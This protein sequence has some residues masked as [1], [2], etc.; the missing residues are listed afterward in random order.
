M[1]AAGEWWWVIPLVSFIGG[2]VAAWGLQSLVANWIT[3]PVI[4]VRLDNSKGSTGEVT[5]NLFDRDGKL[6][7]QHQAKY[8]RLHVE[9]T[10]LSTIKNCSGYITKLTRTVGGQRTGDESEVLDL[11][12]AHK[13]SSNN[14]RDIPSG[15]FFHMDVATLHLLS[16]PDGKTLRPP[17]F[18]TTTSLKDFFKPRGTYELEV[19]I[20]ADNARLPGT[21]PV[22]F[23]YEPSTDNELRIYPLNRV[24]LPWW[25]WCRR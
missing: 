8:I 15:A 6:V 25:A 7:G 12:W 23:D 21:F 5:V 2:S 11:G 20:V 10:G 9:N 13:Q 19:Q 22:Q 3:H 17:N 4:S 14:T 1:T 16:E 18:P 24:R